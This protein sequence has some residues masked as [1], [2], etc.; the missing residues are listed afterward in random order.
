MR[1]TDALLIVSTIINIFLV[2]TQSLASTS[3]MLNSAKE[4]FYEIETGFSDTI[5]EMSTDDP[6]L[7]FKRTEDLVLTCLEGKK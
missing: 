5:G 7:I 1:T 3:K 6:Y 2:S 4:C